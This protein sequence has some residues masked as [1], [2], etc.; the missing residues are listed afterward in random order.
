MGKFN[1]II[2]V[3]AFYHDSSACLFKNGELIFACEEEKFSGIKHD[4]SFPH[5]TL[6]YIFNKYKLNK[7]MI[8]V[9]C[10]YEEP[11]LKLNR[12]LNNI[13]KQWYKTPLY[14]IKSIYNILKI[15][16]NIEGLLKKYSNNIFFSKHHESHIFYS[17][18]TSSFNNTTCVSIDGVGEID[19]TS[20]GIFNEGKFDYVSLSE[21]P[22]S[23]G[24][25]YSAMTSFLGFKPNEGEYKLMGLSSY[26][27]PDVY[28]EKVRELI[29]YKNSNLTCNL[30]VFT[31]H[32]SDKLMFNEK[33][34]ELLDMYPRLENEPIEQKHMDLAS[35]VQ[36]HYEDVI[37][38]ILNTVYFFVD[39]ADLCLGGGCAYNG[40]ANGKILKNTKFKNLWIPVSPSD[41]GSS[42]GA[43]LNYLHTNKQIKNK[44]TKNPF[45][46][47]SIDDDFM[48]TVKQKLRYYK[49]P[50]LD[51]VVE[52]VAKKINNG[53]VVGWVQ[54]RIEFGAR[55]LG[56]RSILA[57]PF[58]ENMRD[59]INNLVKK[60][61]NFR[62][63]AP[64]VIEEKQNQYFEIIGDVPYMNQVVQVKSDYRNVLKATTHI[65]GSARV[66]TVFKN[67]LFH[68][69]LTEFE[70]SSGY[71]ILLNTSFNVKDKTIVLTHKDAIET[72]LE[73][74][75]DILVI[76]NYVFLK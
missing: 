66:Q 27:T 14:S 49:M 22:H 12:V 48:K 18:Y 34:I 8:D 39:S 30:D 62:P 9:I 19:T 54:D 1:Y 29:E 65:D 63:F 68:N 45:L 64:S 32:K 73:T 60:R 55:A 76:N 74:D 71:P 38:G 57:S 61:E 35:A 70:K 15:N 69:L 24:L 5:K 59:R 72:F 3:S 67:T 16:N 10:Y 20:L 33:L 42:I 52:Y 56:H 23:V 46:G 11:K 21:Y 26:G 31:W 2:G 51:R 47:P 37:F 53:M 43:C 25:F 58:D 17:H 41:S 28:I 4:N 36:K 13:K 7:D 6:N 40:I 44:I 75:I 50:N